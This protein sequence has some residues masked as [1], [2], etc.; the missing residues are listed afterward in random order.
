MH[1]DGAPVMQDVSLQG[2]SAA[3]ATTLVSESVETRARGG[4]EA[5]GARPMTGF[6]RELRG[7][8]TSYGW[9][10]RALHADRFSDLE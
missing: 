5:S 10:V 4:G 1:P 2:G 9:S 8:G 7:G 6:A 3:D